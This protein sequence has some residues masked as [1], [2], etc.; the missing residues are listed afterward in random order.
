MRLRAIVFCLVESFPHYLVVPCHQAALETLRLSDISPHLHIA[1]DAIMF[2]RHVN[3]SSCAYVDDIRCCAGRRTLL[4]AS[5][6]Y[7]HSNLLL[8]HLQ[9]LEWSLFYSYFHLSF[10]NCNHKKNKKRMEYTFIPFFN[11]QLF[12]ATVVPATVVPVPGMMPAPPGM[13]PAP[14]GMMPAPPSTPATVPEGVCLGYC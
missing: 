13:M 4:Y 10:D 3:G 5:V 1:I 8:I 6:S 9:V 7:S 11:A 2:F 12:P 14:P